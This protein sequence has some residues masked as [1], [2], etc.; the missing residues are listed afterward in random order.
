MTYAE[1]QKHGEEDYSI[2]F[3]PCHFF[4]GDFE[5]FEKRYTDYNKC[6]ERGVCHE[7]LSN[8]GFIP[9]SATFFYKA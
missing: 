2:E 1:I 9:V 5:K 3:S 4:Q 8:L 7:Y 6:F